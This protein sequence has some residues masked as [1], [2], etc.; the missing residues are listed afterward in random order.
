MVSEVLT[1]W[2]WLVHDDG[3][4]DRATWWLLI[5]WLM[6]MSALFT[7]LARAL[8]G[9]GDA[10]LYAAAYIN[11]VMLY[12]VYCVDAQRFRARGRPPWLALL[13]VLPAALLVLLRIADTA[14]QMQAILGFLLLLVLVWYVADLGLLPNRSA[15][16]PRP[17]PLEGAGRVAALRRRTLR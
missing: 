16:T 9:D 17:T 8:L 3:H 7:E 14:P 1:L 12:P 11:L 13:A 15:D 5:V 4:I 2:R 10:A 6:A